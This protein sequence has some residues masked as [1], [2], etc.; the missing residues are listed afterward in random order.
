VSFGFVRG[1]G[2][3]VATAAPIIDGFVMSG[4]SNDFHPGRGKTGTL[5]AVPYAYNVAVD[6]DSGTD[7]ISLV[8]KTG[9]TGGDDY[10]F[11]LDLYQL[12]F[13][14]L[15]INLCAG[16]T[17]ADDWLTPGGVGDILIAWLRPLLVKAKA[18]YPGARWR[19]HHVRNQGTSDMRV[20]S[21][22]FQQLWSSRSVTWHNKIQDE[23]RAV[24]GATA[25][26]DKFVVQSFTGLTL[27]YFNNPTAHT[28]EIATQQSTY[29][30]GDTDR[31]VQVEEVGY[32]D[33]DGAH[34]TDGTLGGYDVLGHR[35]TE[36]VAPIIAVTAPIADAPTPVTVRR[37]RLPQRL[38]RSLLSRK[39]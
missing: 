8:G 30:A 12:G 2:S 16:S 19:W 31:I 25:V 23:I 34:M 3:L 11:G 17:T 4:Q 26:V 9:L 27:S 36:H 29:V 1:T 39:R 32:Y 6:H 13:S 14:P 20:Y 15:L 10:T 21:L 28:S 5:A 18:L 22:S 33:P 35:L 7:F 38:L 37:P 24:F